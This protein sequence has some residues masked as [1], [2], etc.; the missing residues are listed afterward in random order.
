MNYLIFKK[1]TDLEETGGFWY[2]ICQ[3]ILKL[4]ILRL[5]FI[6]F[7]FAINQSI[8]VRR[9]FPISAPCTARQHRPVPKAPRQC[10]LAAHGGGTERERCTIID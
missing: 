8:I 4:I 9:S 3:L 1:L 2:A 7:N 10:R 5:L 6:Y